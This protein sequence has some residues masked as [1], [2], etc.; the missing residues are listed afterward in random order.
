MAWTHTVRAVS[1]VWCGIA[2]APAGA[3]PQNSAQFP[4]PEKLSYRVEWRLV[5]AGEVSVQMSRANADDW[6]L[7]MEVQSAGLVN[8]LYRVQDQYRVIAN[9][10]FCGVNSDLDAQEGKRHK[11]ML[12]KF[13][14]SQHKLDYEERD[15]LKNTD[16]KKSFDVPGCT[17]E[18]SGALASLRIR[19]LQPGKW[20]TIAITDG[21]KIANGKI[22]AQAR[23]NVA[24]GG[25]TYQ[26]IRCEAFLFDNVLYRRKGRLF[27]WLSDDALHVPVQ[28]RFQLGFPIGTVSV[29]L[30]KREAM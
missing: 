18:I 5:T 29:E 7:N 1:L 10:S 6:K 28:L 9:Q 22:Q 3:S 24:V 15:L 19:D 16:E 23:E 20:W 17:Y 2:F 25:K 12:M 4:C 8:R 30:Q 21:K 14:A 26:T 11:L 13:D 27:I